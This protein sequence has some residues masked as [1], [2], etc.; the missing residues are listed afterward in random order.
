MWEGIKVWE[1]GVS[2]KSYRIVSLRRG[3]LRGEVF[4][5]VVGEVGYS[6]S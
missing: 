4:G 1:D 3:G 2:L 5:D 6:L